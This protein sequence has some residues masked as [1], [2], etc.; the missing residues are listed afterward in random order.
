MRYG[1]VWCLGL[2]LLANPVWA[3]P[4]VS[5]GLEGASRGVGAAF[6][7]GSTLVMERVPSHKDADPWE[8]FNRAIYRFNDTLDRYAL[9]PV[10][11][12]YRKVTPQAVRTGVSNFFLNLRSPVV[13]LNDLLQGKVK[14]AGADTV[15]F[16]VNS[17]VGVVGVLDVATRIRL[18]AHDEDFGQ[19]LGVWGLPAG[20]Y[21]VMPF[22]GPSSVRDAAGFG[23]DAV[24]NPRRYAISNELDWVLVGV[25]VVNSRASLLDLE[26]IIQGDRYLFI[27]DLYLQRREYS[28]RDGQMESDPFLD[29]PEEEPADPA[30]GA[31]PTVTPEALP[32]TE[33]KPA[34]GASAPPASPAAAPDQGSS[35]APA[36]LLS[37]ADPTAGS[38]IP[39]AAAG[40]GV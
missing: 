4:H 2:C 8:G 5:E 30:G 17:T 15:R 21:L 16:V 9:R 33:A 34:D 10:A 22:F 38:A 35:E 29:D 13:V 39:A 11:K 26:D 31:E 12:G 28:V 24:S 7:Q 1:G 6:P 27:R 37:P 14:Q 36:A 20:P 19:T 40:S 23:V 18:P 25:D 32:G 3:A